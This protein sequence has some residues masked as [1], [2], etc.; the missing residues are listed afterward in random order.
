M[1]GAEIEIS[2]KNDIRTNEDKVT[3][4]KQPQKQQAQKDN[5]KFNNCANEDSIRINAAM[6]TIPSW[7]G[8]FFV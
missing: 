5:L 2:S 8:T 3:G 6:A 7:L 4:K 1:F